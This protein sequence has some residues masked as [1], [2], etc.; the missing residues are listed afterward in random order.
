MKMKNLGR[1]L[2]AGCAIYTA[3]NVISLPLGYAFA[4]PSEGLDIASSLLVGSLAMGLLQGL[5]FSEAVFKKLNY[6]VRLIGFALTGMSALLACGWFGNWFPH[7]PG[8]VVTF[9][10]IFLIIFFAILGG[11]T[12]YYKKTAGSYQA[13]LDKYRE[14]QQEKKTR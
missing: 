12:I 14:E 6:A 4:G 1:A 5:W 13:A 10:A 3:S 11:Y 7:E 2:L 9:A 8:V